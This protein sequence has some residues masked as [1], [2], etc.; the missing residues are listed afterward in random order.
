MVR[1]V[2]GA[3]GR[4]ELLDELAGRLHCS[5]QDGRMCHLLTSLCL[6][7]PPLQVGLYGSALLLMFFLEYYNLLSGAAGLQANTIAGHQVNRLSCR[8]GVAC[9]ASMPRLAMLLCPTHWGVR[10]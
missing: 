2:H 4:H 8:P 10:G 7:Y 5:L 9:Q 6:T 3:Q 1:C